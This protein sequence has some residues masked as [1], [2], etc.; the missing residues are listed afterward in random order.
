MLP[1]P[2]DMLQVPAFDKYLKKQI[3]PTV[4]KVVDIVNTINTCIDDIKD[5]ATIICGGYK[6]EVDVKGKSADAVA[7]T[8][9]K[10]DGTYP[11]AEEVDTLT[12]D[13]KV[14]AADDA[15]SKALKA[16]KAAMEKKYVKLK[17]DPTNNVATDDAAPPAEIAA[18]NKALGDLRTAVGANYK[19]VVGHKAAAV[20][21]A[22][23]VRVSIKKFSFPKPD[24]SEYKATDCQLLDLFKSKEAKTLYNAELAIAEAMA[25]VTKAIKAAEEAGVKVTLTYKNKKVAASFGEGKGKKGAAAKG[26]AKKA[27][28]PKKPAAKPK[29][30]PKP[31]EEKAEGEEGEG[32]EK[33][34]GA[35]EGAEAAE[36]AAEEGGAEAEAA[37]EEGGAEAEAGGEAEV[38]GAEE[39]GEEGGDDAGDDGGD[40]DDAGDD[41]A[42]AED[43]DEKAEEGAG[44]GEGGEDGEGGSKPKAAE[45][46]KK[47]LTPEEKAAKKAADEKAAVQEEKKAGVRKSISAL[48]SQLFKLSKAAR[49]SNGPVNVA[50]AL[51]RTFEEMKKK[52]AQLA[53]KDDIK[54]RA[55]CCRRRCC[56]PQP[57][58][59]LR[60][61]VWLSQPDQ[62]VSNSHDDCA[63]C[64]RLLM[65]ISDSLPLPAC[66]LCGCRTSSRSHLA[67]RSA[68]LRRAALPRSTSTGASRSTCLTWRTWMPWTLSGSCCHQQPC[69]SLTQCWLSRTS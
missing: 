25:G 47:V 31:K 48:N 24:S 52:V 41:G 44:G 14:K 55:W 9:T 38:E 63:C 50:K 17:L 16:L 26:G 36:G 21:G 46:P 59:V 51:L 27:A 6:V 61:P 49:N 42:E 13:A 30:A 56:C 12:K 35:E 65:P 10:P 5:A 43:G 15:L 34:E 33:A 57:C 64:P 11:T 20:P 54:V 22:A 4:N 1:A 7:V 28:A 66:C 18:F 8:L 53:G 2:S 60:A 3:E 67:S 40:D 19:V 29:A 58:F 62:F 68:C 39:G 45:K 23:A 37:A 69:W 32:E